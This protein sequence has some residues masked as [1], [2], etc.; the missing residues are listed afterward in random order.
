MA[1]PRAGATDAIGAWADGRI[2]AGEAAPDRGPRPAPTATVRAVV[3][4]D[5]PVGFVMLSLDEAAPEYYLWRSMIDQ[6]YQGR[7]DGRAAILQVIEHVRTL[8]N[9]AELL[10]SWVPEPGGPKPFYRA[11]GFQPN[12]EMD[13][14]EVVARLRL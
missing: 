4:D 11:L 6:R 5:I 9:A 3:A 14:D 1:D 7:G 8:P 2:A 13:G 12:G 10:V